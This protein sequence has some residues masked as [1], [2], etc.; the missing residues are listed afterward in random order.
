MDDEYGPVVASFTRAEFF[1][2]GTFIAIPP[3]VSS[4]AGLKMPVIIT[5]GVRQEFVTGDG[6]EDDRLRAVLSAVARAVE[7]APVGEVCFVVPAGEL[8]CGREPIGADRLIAITEPGDTGEPV[9]TMMLPG[10]M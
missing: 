5:V 6:G 4:A 2:D 7:Q 8:P 9:L 3:V 1:A 10:E